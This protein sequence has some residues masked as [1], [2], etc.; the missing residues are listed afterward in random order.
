MNLKNIFQLLL[1]AGA[2]ALPFPLAAEEPPARD[3]PLEGDMVKIPAGHFIF[4]TNRKDEAAEALSLGIPKPWYAD[5]NPEQKIFLKGFYIDRFE[6]TRKRYKIYIDDVGAIAPEAWN[7]SAYAEGTGEHPV[8]GV[9]WFDAANFCQWAGKKLPS[10][11]Q[12]ERAARGAQGNEYPWG[13]EFIEGAANLSG[14]AGSKN[15]AGPVGSFPKGVSP[16][17]AH[18]LVGNVWEWVEDDYAPYQGS[19]HQSPEYGAG[20]KVLRGHSARDIG[21]FPGASY[22][23]AIQRFA[24]SGYRQF[25]HPDEPAPDVGFRCASSEK[26]AAMKAGLAFSPPAPAGN[27]ASFPPP[28]EAPKAAGSSAPF[29]GGEEDNPFAAKPN[30]PQSGIL[31][32]VLL[33]FV[34]GVFSF[35]S[36][37]TLPILPAYFAIT[38]QTDRARIGLMSLAFFFGL[39]TLFV[40]MGASASLIGRVLRDYLFSLTTAAGVLVAL[41]G[42]MTVFGKGFSGA[43]FQGRPASSFF[44]FF[45]FG[46]TFAL[47]WTPCVGPILSGILILAASDKTVFQ[48]MTLLFFYAIG[49]GLPLMLISTFCG[50]LPKDGLFWRVLRGKGWTVTLAGR[51]VLLHTTNLASGLL[52]IL[53]GVALAMGMLTYINSLIPIELQ[54]WFSEFEEKFLHLFM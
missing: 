31:V 45:L 39:A 17:G 33:S 18:D 40:M 3:N 26:P 25:L 4:G 12:W 53:L 29:G 19:T 21:H 32:L 28:G 2:F 6:V 22:T 24:R 27:T 8:V 30:L 47:G 15:T 34:A 51:P 16:E 41:F 11:K 9:T 14:R 13:N 37:C 46:A 1:V 38:A 49:L 20:F 48:G 10:E 23:A 35:L 42:V 36:P 52:L 54:I 5:E 50:H 43:T 44:G 7:N